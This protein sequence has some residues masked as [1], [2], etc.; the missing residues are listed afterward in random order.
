MSSCR[1]RVQSQSS[2]GRW[3]GLGLAFVLATSSQAVDSDIRVVPQVLYG[4]SGLEPGLAVE[5]AWEWRG[6]TSERLLLRPEILLNEDNRV[7]FGAAVLYDLTSFLILPE[8]HFMAVGPRVVYH[9]AD[10]SGMEADAMA[11]WRYELSGDPES[12]GHHFLGALGALGVYR[13]RRHDSN[14]VGMSA[15]GFYAFRF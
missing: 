13:D 15:G 11:T 4:T 6:P 14:E 8:R 7:G 12:A 5:M 10:D 9:N 2:P 3:C 1:T